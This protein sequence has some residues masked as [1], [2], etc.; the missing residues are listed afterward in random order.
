MRLGRHL[1]GVPGEGA[2]RWPS[3]QEGYEGAE[4]HLADDAR[5]LLQM[6][7]TRTQGPHQPLGG[8]LQLSG[9]LLRP[10]ESAFLTSSR[11]FNEQPGLTTMKT[12]LCGLLLQRFHDGQK[13][14]PR[15]LVDLLGFQWLKPLS[16]GAPVGPA[17]RE[18]PSHHH[19]TWLRPRQHLVLESRRP[20][21]VGGKQRPRSLLGWQSHPDSCPPHSARSFQNP[22]STP[23]PARLQQAASAPP[24]SAGV[25]KQRLKAK[26]ERFRGHTMAV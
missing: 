3:G 23:R 5:S 25:T 24:P 16:P 9:P 14:R 21:C 19:I 12:E 17:S 20:R 7:V 1:Q 13:A 26:N 15:P 6:R 4:S 2:L 22:D 11:G 8:L 18:P 10:R